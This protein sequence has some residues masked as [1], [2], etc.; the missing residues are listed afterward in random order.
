MVLVIMGSQLDKT[1]LAWKQVWN[2]PEAFRTLVEKS[3]SGIL[4]VNDKYAI[5]YVNERVCTILGCTREELLSHDFRNFLHPDTIDLVVE[6]YSRML[7]GSSISACYEMKIIRSDAEVRDLE[8]RSGVVTNNDEGIK[9]AVQ[10]LDVTEEKKTKQALLESEQKFRKT[11]EAITDPA[12]IWRRNPDGCIV[13][14]AVNQSMMTFSKGAMMKFIDNDLDVAFSRNPEICTAIR[15]TMETGK[16]QRMELPYVTHHGSRRWLIWDLTKPDDDLVLLITT[17]I[18]ERMIME[19]QLRNAKEKAILYLDLL[20]HDMGNQLQVM[21][22]FTERHLERTQDP[23]A[24]KLAEYTLAS[25]ARCEKIM[26]KTK[27]IEHIMIQPL[28]ERI[29]DDALQH[30][31]EA[32]KR[33]CADVTV[34]L[35]IRESNAQVI[36]DDFLE[37]LFM[38]ILENACEHHSGKDRHIWVSLETKNDSYEVSISDNGSGMPDEAKE[39]LFD[40]TRRF[41][42]VGLHLAHHLVEKYGGTIMVLDRVVGKPDRGVK[43]RIMLPNAKQH[44]D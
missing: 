20:G 17:D 10:I 9:I 13:L 12:F 26:S 42:G 14:H 4:L 29:L 1:Y 11:F 22:G 30:S 36:A 8:I 16:A 35:S 37:L 28:K 19:R 7:D 15:H 34:G 41:G 23:S 38:T 31:V 43:F 44:S 25:I 33:S 24:A 18:T 5:E 32:I 39:I 6:S 40:P 27:T 2:K 21:K 3:V